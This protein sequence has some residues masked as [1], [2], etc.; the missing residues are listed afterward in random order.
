MDA[1]EID[2]AQFDDV[3][4]VVANGDAS[5]ALD[6]VSGAEVRAVERTLTCSMVV[7]A[8]VQRGPSRGPATDSSA[9]DPGRLSHARAGSAVGDEL[10]ATVL[11]T[12]LFEQVQPPEPNSTK[13]LGRESGVR[14]EAHRRSIAH[15]LSLVIF[16]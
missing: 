8:T 4:L 11:R 16:P 3:E 7:Q 2:H 10:R 9:A 14:G 12:E 13:P 6:L 1:S 5:E 15:I